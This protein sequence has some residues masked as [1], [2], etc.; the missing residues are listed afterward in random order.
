[1]RTSR[2]VLNVSITLRALP[3]LERFDAARRLGFDQVELWWPFDSPTPGDDEVSSLVAALDSAGTRL[4]GL[5]LFAGDMP[6]G[7]RG[8]AS[9]PERAGELAANLDAVVAIAEATGC[10]LFNCLY[11]HRDERWSDQEQA[12][13]ADRAIAGAADRLAPLDGIVLIECLA[14]GENGPYPLT[15][16]EDCAAVTDR[17]N[18]LSTHGNVAPLLDLYHLARNGFDIV[19]SAAQWA[20]RVAHCQIADAPGRHEPGT[21]DLPLREAIDTLYANGYQGLVA[22]EFVPASADGPTTAWVQDLGW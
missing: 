13:T 1:M 3:L 21:G 14:E 17:A 16:L 10:R 6:A 19:E 18:A 11:G 20:K 5:N 7:E 9:N 15:S 2:P 22:G 12:A 4:R 8:V